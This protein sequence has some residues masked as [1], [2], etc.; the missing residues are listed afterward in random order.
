MSGKPDTSRFVVKPHEALMQLPITLSFPFTLA[1]RIRA[2]FALIPQRKL[3]I[4]IH[5]TI[6]MIGLATLVSEMIQGRPISADVL[7]IVLACFMFT[8]VFLVFGVTVNHRFNKSMREP[9]TYSF[10]TDGIHVAATTYEFTHKWA[11]I[12]RVKI[13]GGF[14]MFFFTPGNA[15][16]IPLGAVQQSGT[17]TPLLQLASAQGVKV[18]QIGP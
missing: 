15:H 13:F 1:D 18:S 9:F 5:A 11:A 6:P 4:A 8:P 2:A 16:C 10:D 17:L 3:N 12:S 14:L 7:F